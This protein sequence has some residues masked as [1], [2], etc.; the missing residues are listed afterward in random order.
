[1]AGVS[2]NEKQMMIDIMEI[3]VMVTCALGAGWWLL[4]EI[5]QRRKE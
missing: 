1:L 3:L 4:H 5:R 2:P